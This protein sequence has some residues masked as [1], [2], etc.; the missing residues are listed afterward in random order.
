M[1]LGGRLRFRRRA[2]GKV[3]AGSTKVFELAAS[4]LSA[5]DWAEFVQQVKRAAQRKGVKIKKI[6]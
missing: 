2:K 3:V 5:A 1:S 4:G 6:S